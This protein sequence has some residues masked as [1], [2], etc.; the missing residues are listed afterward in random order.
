M[1]ELCSVYD[2]V[3]QS[4]AS[5]TLKYINPRRFEPR[6]LEEALMAGGTQK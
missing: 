2:T 5:E 6:S 3:A 4:L 1:F